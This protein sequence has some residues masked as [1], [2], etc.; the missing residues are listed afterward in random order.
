MVIDREVRHHRDGTTTTRYKQEIPLTEIVRL[1]TVSE[2]VIKSDE[3]LPS[4]T[5]IKLRKEPHGRR[6]YTYLTIVSPMGAPNQMAERTY[7]KS[8][9]GNML[10]AYIETLDTIT[11]L[12]CEQEFKEPKNLQPAPVAFGMSVSAG[13]PPPK[14]VKD[15]LW[16]IAGKMRARQRYHLT[17]AELNKV[18]EAAVEYNM[19]DLAQA[20]DIKDQEQIWVTIRD[21]LLQD[22]PDVPSMQGFVDNF[23]NWMSFVK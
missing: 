3:P 7:T 12:W 1:V 10:N 14:T 8:D 15:V 20:I 11:V 9:V 23:C 18:Q 2:K 22:Y 17:S 4:N 13:T 21:H 6:V 5:K 19:F 16:D